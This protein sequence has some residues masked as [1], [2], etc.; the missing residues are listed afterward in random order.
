MES[1][2]GCL[3]CPDICRYARE[4]LY[5]RILGP[6]ITDTLPQSDYGRV[7]DFYSARSAK[8]GSMVDALRA[9]R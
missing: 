1:R 4:L 3:I 9:G 5:K 6:R 2:D 8:I 7:V